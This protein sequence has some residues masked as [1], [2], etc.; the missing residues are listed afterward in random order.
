[1]QAL[2]S[3]FYDYAK[4]V[5]DRKREGQKSTYTLVERVFPLLVSAPSSCLTADSNSCLPDLEL[6]ALTKWLASRW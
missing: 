1:M 6:G 5:E 3:L 2:I 4:E